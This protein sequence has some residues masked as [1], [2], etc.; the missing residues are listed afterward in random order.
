MQ[1][2]RLP[3]EK[4]ESKWDFFSARNFLKPLGKVYSELD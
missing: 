4:S 3:A 1:A 2:Q